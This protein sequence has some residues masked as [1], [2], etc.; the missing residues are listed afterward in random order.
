MRLF[1]RLTRACV[2]PISFIAKEFTQIRRQP[3][4]V[5]TLIVGPFLVLLLFG[6][7]YNAKPQSIRTV[8]VMPTDIN[9]STNVA[10]YKGQFNPPFLLVGVTHDRNKAV[11]QLKDG[12]IDAVLIFPARA[13]QTIKSGHQ[14][15][16]ELLYDELAPIQR[17][18]L[19]YYGFVQT[20]EFNRQ[21]MTKVLKQSTISAKQGSTSDATTA[22]LIAAAGSIPTNVL[23][24]PFKPDSKNLAPTTPNFVSY[25]APAVL[26][27][28]VQH[29]AVTLTALALVRERLSGSI[30]LF[31]IGPISS[32]EVLIGK[33]VSYLVQAAVLSAILVALMLL[34]LNVPVLGTLAWLAG[35]LALLIAASLGLGFLISA[36]STTETQAVQLSLL[37]LLASVFFSGFFLPL[38]NLLKPVWAVTYSLPVSYGI[39]SLQGIMLRGVPPP[40]WQLGALAGMALGFAV[41]SGLIF[42]R[43]FQRQ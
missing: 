6:V 10:D 20:S 16:M 42:R 28:L 29:I 5:L 13:Y 23:V 21:V 40:A 2:R 32:G 43:L 25:Y 14:A 22:A 18:W 33:Y 36:V 27:L 3:R 7:G 15:T 4:L 12:D 34:A 30:E 37:V 41:L 19:Q 38:H 9:Y 11:S 31:R 39:Q 1:D 24:S 8:L 17:T 35:T 26:A